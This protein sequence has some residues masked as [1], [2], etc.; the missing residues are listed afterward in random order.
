MLAGWVA[1]W[2]HGWVRGWVGGWVGWVV[3]GRWCESGC[4][5]MST[6]ELRIKSLP[7]L[8]VIEL[9]VHSSE[10]C[11]KLI[12]IYFTINST[13]YHQRLDIHGGGTAYPSSRVPTKGAPMTILKRLDRRCHIVLEG[14]ALSSRA[15]MEV[16]FGN[17]DEHKDRTSSEN[18]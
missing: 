6:F 14:G 18:F 11:E 9:L 4:W 10:M 17:N 1:C 8:V 5:C 16:S 3:G 7:L 12:E 13:R 15:L 2:L